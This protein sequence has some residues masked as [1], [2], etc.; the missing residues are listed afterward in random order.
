MACIPTLFRR[1]MEVGT[2]LSH[3]RRD[4]R[5]L[6]RIHTFVLPALLQVFSLASTAQ[7]NADQPHI[8]QFGPNLWVAAI[9]Q[10]PIARLAAPESMGRQRRENWCWAASVQMVLNLAGLQ[11]T[12]E[13]VVARIF[14]GDLD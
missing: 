12:Q 9:E 11:V 14:G 2:L 13:Q 7:I 5:H 6:P 4:L 3:I 10:L 1:R 8:R